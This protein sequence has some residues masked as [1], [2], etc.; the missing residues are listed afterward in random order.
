MSPKDGYVSWCWEVATD[1]GAVHDL[2]CR[3]DAAQA[4][5]FDSPVPVRRQETS[6]RRVALG[7]VH[8]L[9]RDGRVA[10]MFTLSPD[11]PFD[12]EEG[13]FAP[14]AQAQHLSRL[15]VAPTL[16]DTEILVGTRCVRRAVEVAREA[17]ASVLRAEAN[18][19]LADTVELLVLLGFVQRGPVLTDD[20]GRRRVFVEKDLRPAR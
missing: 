17:D 8:L 9:R 12:D 18:P 7:Q 11:L 16:L 2:L 6:E 4:I 3:S 14:V 1:A 15:A 10:A 19:D 13:T 20:L 5:R